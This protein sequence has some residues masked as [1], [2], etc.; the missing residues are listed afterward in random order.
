MRPRP[1][2]LCR[3]RRVMT[4]RN[5]R[6]LGRASLVG[7]VPRRR[8]HANDESLMPSKRGGGQLRSRP[9][10]LVVS[11]RTQG[12]LWAQRQRAARSIYDDMRVGSGLARVAGITSSATRGWRRTVPLSLVAALG[13][14]HFGWANDP[15]VGV[16]FGAWVAA[17]APPSTKGNT[18]VPRRLATQRLLA[19]PTPVSEPNGRD[20]RFGRCAC[21]PN[22]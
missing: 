13:G 10:L 20:S 12:H 9:R 11:T 2:S 5:Q 4:G 21:R 18:P 16:V 6:R 3:G 22:T 17:S 19:R 8:R 14:G 15:L 1:P 7:R